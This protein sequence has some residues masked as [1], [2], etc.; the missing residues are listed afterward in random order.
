MDNFR[1]EEI[2]ESLNKENETTSFR[3]YLIELVQIVLLSV[4]FFIVI[5]TFIGRVR[6]ENISMEPTLQPGEF[7]MVNKFAYRSGNYQRGDIII[8]HAPPNP[9][10]DY[11][12]RLIGLPGDEILII[13]GKVSVNETL[14]E[15]P[16]ISAPPKYSGSWTVPEKSIFVLGDNRNSSEDSHEWGFVPYDSIVG[17]ALVIYWPFNEFRILDHPKFMVSTN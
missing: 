16:Y 3:R 1:S 6:V 2:T 12:K 14:L 13:N 11:I 15:E 5:D 10:V 7:I 4:F 8:F 9:K 17:R